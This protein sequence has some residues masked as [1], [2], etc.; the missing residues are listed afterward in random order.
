MNR[1]QLLGGAG[2]LSLLALSGCTTTTPEQALEPQPAP[3]IPGTYATMY[4]PM[5]GERFPI[6]A[7][8]LNKV[9][10]RFWRRQVDYSGPHAVGT[11]IVDTQTFYLHLIQEGGKAMRYGVGLGRAGFSWSGRG[12]I[13]WKQAWPK[14]TPPEEMIAREPDLEKWSARNGGMPPGLDNP[15][16]ARALYIFQDGEDTLYRIHGSPEYWTIGRAVSSG[17]VRLMNQD[18]IDLYSRVPSGSSLVVV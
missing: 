5:P 18:I 13:Q 12:V 11:L 17:C 4:G 2:S 14:W 1:R 6:P 10:E 8:D 7:V 16:G 3:R 9:P 15:L